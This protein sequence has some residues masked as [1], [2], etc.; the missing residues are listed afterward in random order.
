VNLRLA[1]GVLQVCAH[2]LSA[3]RRCVTSVHSGRCFSRRA[4]VCIL[5][6]TPL[7]LWDSS[8][9]TTFQC[10]LTAVTSLQV[11]MTFPSKQAGTSSTAHSKQ[12]RN[13]LAINPQT[14]RSVPDCLTAPHKPS[15]ERRRCLP[16]H[17]PQRSG[18]AS[19]SPPDIRRQ[20]PRPGPRSGNDGWPLTRRRPHDARTWAV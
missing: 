5:V 13:V 8:S 2:A 7:F 4:R 6:D 16:T 20:P 14:S 18:L 11:G 1:R 19:R 15:P 12:S 9:M 17:H 10:R 3:A